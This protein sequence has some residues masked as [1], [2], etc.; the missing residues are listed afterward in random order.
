MPPDETHH[1]MSTAEITS[2]RERELAA[3]RYASSPVA[4]LVR[5]LEAALASIDDEIAEHGYPYALGALDARVRV[6]IARVPRRPAPPVTARAAC[7]C[8]RR[9]PSASTA[10]RRRTR[11]T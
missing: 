7:S 5:E 3:E 8:S 11:S 2:A 1:D 6:A 10:R 9:R 4:A